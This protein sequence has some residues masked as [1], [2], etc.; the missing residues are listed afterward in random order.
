MRILIAV[1]VLLLALPVGAQ[2]WVQHNENEVIAFYYDPTTIRFTGQFHRVWELQDF[3]NV[4]GDHGKSSLTLWEIDCADE[5]MR[6][7]SDL[8]L[9]ERMGKGDTVRQATHSPP[10]QWWY[11]PPGQ[12]HATLLNVVCAR[13]K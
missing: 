6:S 1:L 10:H 4:R 9:R 7:L 8:T 2:R 3:K 5:R 12:P 13:R 11:V